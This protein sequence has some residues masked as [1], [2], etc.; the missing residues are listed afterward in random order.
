MG[1]ARTHL[2]NVLTAAAMNITRTV[3][4][5]NDVARSKTRT[6]HFAALAAA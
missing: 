6:S 2:Q 4:W 1:L 5:L 3:A